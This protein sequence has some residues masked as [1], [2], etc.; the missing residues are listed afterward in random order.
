VRG[1]SV[2]GGCWRPWKTAHR[3]T[4]S[5]DPATDGSQLSG[6]SVK[7]QR[8][9]SH[10]SSYYARGWASPDGLPS[11]DFSRIGW[12]SSAR[13]CVVIVGA[14]ITGTVAGKSRRSRLIFLFV[15]SL[16]ATT[17]SKRRRR[18]FSHE[19]LSCDPP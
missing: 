13:P 19:L 15:D 6:Y 2:A 1:L 5:P 9:R 17:M 7:L 14:V 10:L 8:P 4:Q 12:R 18:L 3:G 16:G 11:T